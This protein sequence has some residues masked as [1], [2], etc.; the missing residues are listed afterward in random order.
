MRTW[1]IA[2]LLGFILSPSGDISAHALNASLSLTIPNS[3]KLNPSEPPPPDKE[4]IT[5]EGSLPLIGRIHLPVLIIGRKIFVSLVDFFDATN[6]Y[7]E[8]DGHSIHGFIN[9]GISYHFDLARNT[10]KYGT[11]AINLSTENSYSIG[12]KFYFSDTALYSLFGIRI[13]FDYTSLSAEIE[14]IVEL[15]I[16]AKVRREQLY[17]NLS[18][19]PVYSSDALYQSQSSLLNMNGIDWSVTS[20]FSFPFKNYSTY[21]AIIG[22]GLLGGNYWI[23]PSGSINAS[24]NWHL[25]QWN[26]KHTFESAAIKQ[27]TIGDR[28]NLQFPMYGQPFRG[29][30]ITNSP[31]IERENF[32]S[33]SFDQPLVAG[34]V[35]ELYRNGELMSYQNGDSRIVVPMTLPYGMTNFTRKIYGKY[36][37]EYDE[38]EVIRIPRSLLPSGEVQYAVSGGVLGSDYNNILSE[39]GLSA[40]FSKGL[41]VSG[42]VQYY[43]QTGFNSFSPFARIQSNLS[44]NLFLLA[45]YLY[46]G[47]FHVSLDYLSA[48][49]VQVITD[50]ARNDPRMR[51]G[52]SQPLERMGLQLTLPVRI[53]SL[54]ISI[55]AKALE[56]SYD[57]LT[58]SI[59]T[60]ISTS[61]F[62]RGITL[63]TSFD[64]QMMADY[65]SVTMQS[66][67]S[68][69]GASC[70]LFRNTRAQAEATYDHTSQVISN[71]LLSITSRIQNVDLTVGVQKPYNFPISLQISMGLNLPSVSITGSGNVS[72]DHYSSSSSMQGSLRF[73]ESPLDISLSAN[74]VV[75]TA[76]AVFRPYLDV[77]GNGRRDADEHS[78]LNLGIESNYGIQNRLPD[79]SIEV[80]YLSPY[81]ILHFKCQTDAVEEP[82]WK[83]RSE[84]ITLVLQ[85]D[86]TQIIDLPITPVSEISGVVIWAIK[87]IKQPLKTWTIIIRDSLNNEV[88]KI[89]TEDDGTFYY[90]GL[91]PGNYTLECDENDR[92]I[93]KVKLLEPVHFTIKRANTGVS[94]EGIKIILKY[95]SAGGS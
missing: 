24:T 12:S 64:G 13:H 18:P 67:R 87:T 72:G 56:Y 77:N 17:K 92:K 82:T 34:Q 94:L 37:E 33:Y 80:N 27:L 83:P 44:N 70:P 36:G 38:V 69:L 35:V 4:E 84:N 7:Y 32:S 46:Q 66:F 60:T 8:R 85:P 93:Q 88:A 15:P 57:F 3:P 62:L 9:K 45:D 73:G 28:I 6:I 79:G 50:Y 30:Q 22:G 20:S 39:A 65:Q 14:S 54:P 48:G 26:W 81:Q 29:L 2:A 10:A 55:R 74:P 23:N 51:F 1:A 59:S 31:F 58:R 75:S 61:F 53:S 43:K 47:R 91:L 76:T 41:T 78:V 71:L 25:I 21:R 49:G 19:V 42:G 68:T 95:D 40:G 90:S 86:Q 11:T 5:I 63:I 52:F 89:R 16:V